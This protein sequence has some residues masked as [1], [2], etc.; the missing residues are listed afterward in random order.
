[1]SKMQIAIIDQLSTGKWMTSSEIAELAGL[2]RP[3]TRVTL[4][5]MTRDG[6]IIKKDDPERLGK[7]LYK[8]TD[9]P[10]GFGI[11]QSMAAFDKFLRE[12]RQ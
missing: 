3:Y 4:A 12:V 6:L 9:L 10:C 5:T 11:S 7:V 8:K 2:P 1:M